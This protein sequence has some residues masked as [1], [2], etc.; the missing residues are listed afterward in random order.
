ML[1]TTR[2]APEKLTAD[3]GNLRESK[4]ARNDENPDHLQA[5][6][7]FECRAEHETDGR[8]D[9]GAGCL[10]QIAARRKFTDHGTDKGA[11]EHTRE[12]E[13]KARHSA[14]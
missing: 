4:K 8:A 3:I 11:K 10:L 6:R 14:D 5:E 7:Q 9:A 13:E 12:A 1:W 2:A